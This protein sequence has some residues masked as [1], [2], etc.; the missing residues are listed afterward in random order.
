MACHV[1]VMWM[2]VPVPCLCLPLPS[3]LP[4]RPPWRPNWGWLEELVKHIRQDG[5]ACCCC[6]C[7]CEA[8]YN[9]DKLHLLDAACVYCLCLDITLNITTCIINIINNNNSNNYSSSNNSSSRGSNNNEQ[10]RQQQAKH[11]LVIRLISPRSA[12]DEVQEEEEL[13]ELVE[14]S[15]RR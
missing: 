1:A 13:W 15:R 3:C 7:C 11:A 9:C 4:C 6:R 12:Q 5:R 14:R 2:P 8:F 10:Q